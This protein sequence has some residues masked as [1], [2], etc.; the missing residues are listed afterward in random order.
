[1]AA[2]NSLGIV[3]SGSTAFPGSGA[4]SGAPASRISVVKSRMSYNGTAIPDSAVRSVT[5]NLRIA[6]PGVEGNITDV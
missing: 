4:F 6:Y 3:V 5:H 1:M 2:S